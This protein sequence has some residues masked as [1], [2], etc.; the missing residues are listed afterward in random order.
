MKF[1]KINWN[2]VGILFFLEII[3][4]IF[5]SII[6]FY[7]VK[8]IIDRMALVNELGP[9]LQGLLSQ[10]QAQSLEELNITGVTNQVSGLESHIQV[11]QLLFFLV[12][13]FLFVVYVFFQ[14][15]S[16]DLA[17]KKKIKLP[18]IF[19]LKYFLGFL[20]VTAFYLILIYIL[21]LIFFNILDL[22]TYVVVMTFLAF[23]WF[24]F[25]LV[26]YASLHKQK[27]VWKSVL[28]GFI[29]GFREVVRLFLIYLFAVIVIIALIG[30]FSFFSLAGLWLIILGVIF[31]FIFIFIKIYFSSVV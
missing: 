16:W 10:I 4:L 21:G 2:K 28:A 18:K 13:F 17:N 8:T 30:I 20:G 1:K 29:S 11:L 3:F 19:D 9:Q 12:P 26:S 6:G 25:L 7:G 23:I 5:F 24:Y 15:I 14:S 27:K 22:G 31:V